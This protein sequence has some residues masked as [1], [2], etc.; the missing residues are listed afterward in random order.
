MAEGL[1][2]NELQGLADVES[3]GTHTWGDSTSSA[4][5]AVM[6]SKFGIDISSHR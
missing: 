6:R 2:R 4:A 3:A 1:A 5:V